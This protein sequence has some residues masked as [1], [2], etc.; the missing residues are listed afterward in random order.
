MIVTTSSFGFVPQG[1]QANE[2]MVNGVGQPEYG[3][4]AIHNAVV[5]GANYANGFWNGTNGITSSVAANDPNELHAVG[6]LD[7]STAGG[8]Y[9]TFWGV[10]VNTS[11]TIIATTYYGDADLS[12]YVDS[13]DYGLWV[14]TKT[15][16]NP[17]ISSL[18]GG[19]VEWVDGDFDQ[20][21]TVD[22]GDYGLWVI[23]KT[24]PYNTPLGFNPS[25]VGLAATAASPS[26]GG[27]AAV[28]EP[29]TLALLVLLF[30]VASPRARFANCGRISSVNPFPENQQEKHLC[31]VIA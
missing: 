3:A 25:A 4:A 22:S 31:R 18:T 29:G 5:E 26:I 16:P 2:Y 17:T 8:I 28:P 9:S 27:V 24:S 7:D 6:Y 19:P 23:S 14:I 15:S 11:Q 10:P 21:G 30:F 20:S 1:G 12:G 13:G